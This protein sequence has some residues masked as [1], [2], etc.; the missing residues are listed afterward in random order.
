M[1][2][3]TATDLAV[4]DKLLNMGKLL[5]AKEPNIPQ[6]LVETK[7]GAKRKVLDLTFVR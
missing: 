7:H 3:H 4:S 6:L 5:S 1:E 2:H